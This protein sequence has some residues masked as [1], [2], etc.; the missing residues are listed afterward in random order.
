MVIHRLHGR[1]AHFL[2]LPAP[3]RCLRLDFL[4]IMLPETDIHITLNR[5]DILQD[6]LDHALLNRPAEEIELAHRGL[7]DGRVAANLEADALSATKRVKEALRIGLE[8]ALVM[9]VHHEL[10]GQTC[11]IRKRV[12]DVELLGIVR[13]EPVNEAETHGT[14][15]SQNGQ[16]LFESPRLVIKILEPTDDE[17]LFALDAALLGLSEWCWIH[18]LRLQVV[19]WFR[20]A[21]E[22]SAVLGRGPW[23]CQLHRRNLMHL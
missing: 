1:L 10:T 15:A 4:A 12:A 13:D 11:V 22:K 2:P 8:L 16:H 18:G 23:L 17:I 5:N 20:W 14:A 9:E 21:Q 3:R 19:R 7:F 6:I